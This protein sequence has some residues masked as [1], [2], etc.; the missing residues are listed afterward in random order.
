MLKS[1]RRQNSHVYLLLSL[2]SA[3]QALVTSANFSEKNPSHIQPLHL[4]TKAFTG[5]P[6]GSDHRAAHL[7]PTRGRRQRFIHQCLSVGKYGILVVKIAPIKLG[8]EQGQQYSTRNF[9]P[10]RG[11]RCVCRGICC[12]PRKNAELPVYF[13]RFTDISPP[14]SSPPRQ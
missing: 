11:I 8:N 2:T 9:T 3:T 4:S 14:V 12:L 13:A 7:T 5:T 10:R 6:S 1:R